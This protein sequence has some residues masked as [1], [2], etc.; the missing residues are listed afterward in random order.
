MKTRLFRLLR[1]LRSQNWPKYLS[2][3]VNAINHSSNSAIGGLYPANIKLPSDGP[4]IDAAIGVV[5]DTPFQSQLSNQKKYVENAE[6]IQKNDF[7]FVD[8]GP[9]AM[10]KGYDSPVIF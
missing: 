8:F 9:S 1:T 6:G 7:V 5:Q 10:A 4:K 2:D 3:V